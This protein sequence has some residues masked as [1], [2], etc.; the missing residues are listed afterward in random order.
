VRKRVVTQICTQQY[1]ANNIKD[2]LEQANN[3]QQ[4]DDGSNEWEDLDDVID[5]PMLNKEDVLE[6]NPVDE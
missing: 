2:A 1:R 4:D 5:Y 3:E 6:S